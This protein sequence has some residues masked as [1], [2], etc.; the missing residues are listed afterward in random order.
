MPRYLI[1]GP[2]PSRK[3]RQDTWR[4]CQE[5]VKRGWVRSI[6]VSN[7]GNHHIDEIEAVGGG[8]PCTVNQI[9]LRTPLQQ[10]FT[11]RMLTRRRR[12]LHA[13]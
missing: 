10:S 12:P 9:D 7:F 3:A 13:P 8:I 2:Q 4:A 6:G 1:H 11:T 5:A